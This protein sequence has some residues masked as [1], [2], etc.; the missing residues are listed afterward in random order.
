[1]LRLCL[2]IFVCQLLGTLSM[3]LVRFGQVGNPD[4]AALFYS[5][6]AGCAILCA[7]VLWLVRKP[8]ELENFRFRF[9]LMLVCLY[10]GLTFGLVANRVAGDLG[11]L[12]PTL[13][14]VIAAMSFQG[15]TL[16]LTRRFVLEHQI[17]LASAFGF[18][19]GLPLAV[20]YG[21]MAAIFFLPVGKVMQIVTGEILTRFQW[22][23]EAQP[24]VQALQGTTTW[25]E[26]AAIAVV[27]IG[28]APVAEEILF[29]GILYPTIKRMGH[30]HLAFWGNSVL[31]AAIHINLPTFF[32]L[33]LLALVLTWLYEKTGNLLAPITTHILFNALNFFLFYQSSWYEWL[34][35]FLYGNPSE[36]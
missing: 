31:F 6:A 12:N 34:L 30:P 35:R 28:L 25:M 36:T 32:P 22:N 10:V 23:F 21:T 18:R 16:W 8:W 29:R 24:A 17:T 20:L 19:L 14:T 9:A 7:V 1:M 13:R 15:A 2:G 26:S 27:A 4:K 11:Q 5:S 33:L 3:V